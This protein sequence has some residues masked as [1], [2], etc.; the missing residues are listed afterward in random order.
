M[1]NTRPTPGKVGCRY[2]FEC[3]AVVALASMARAA[4]SGCSALPAPVGP[5]AMTLATGSVRAVAA[6]GGLLR[7]VRRGGRVGRDAGRRLRELAVALFP[8][9]CKPKARNTPT[10]ASTTQH[11][12][13]D[14]RDYPALPRVPVAQRLERRGVHER[15][16]RAGIHDGAHRAGVPDPA[17]RPGVLPLAAEVASV[18]AAE[19]PR[20]S[21]LRRLRRAGGAEARG[22]RPGEGAGARGA[23]WAGVAPGSPFPVTISTGMVGQGG[24]SVPGGASARAGRLTPAGRAAAG[25]ARPRTGC[26]LTARGRVSRRGRRGASRAVARR[27]RRCLGGSRRGTRSRESPWEVTVPG[28]GVA[29]RGEW[30]SAARRGRPAEQ[31]G[32][33]GSA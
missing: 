23:V 18:R 12:D 1:S 11:G 5:Q 8:P 15:A 2:H 16:H 17:E 32:R 7:S 25:H 22:P 28:E 9:P 31:P 13:H 27:S 10:P 20:R 30:G 26:L 21:R 3:Q 4:C 29:R 19:W 14:G 24:A 6:R 33:R